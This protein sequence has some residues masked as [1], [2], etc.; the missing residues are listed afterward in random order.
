MC[1]K[2]MRKRGSRN[3]IWE[4]SVPIIKNEVFANALATAA[5]VVDAPGQVLFRVGVPNCARGTSDR[6]TLRSPFAPCSM[7]HAARSVHAGDA[8]ATS[9]ANSSIDPTLRG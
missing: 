8:S 6:F 2:V 1:E 3:E 9:P 5:F 7:L 4:P